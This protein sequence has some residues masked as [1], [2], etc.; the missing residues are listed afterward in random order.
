MKITEKVGAWLQ[1]KGHTKARLADELHISTVSLNSKLRDETE[2]TWEQVVALSEIL[3]CEL[4]D[5]KD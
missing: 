4:K 2:W 1:M 3:G 5:L